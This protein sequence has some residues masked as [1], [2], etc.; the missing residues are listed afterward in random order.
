MMESNEEQGPR[1]AAPRPFG[2]GIS[3]G[4]GDG[5]GA[6]DSGGVGSPAAGRGAP[7]AERGSRRPATFTCALGRVWPRAVAADLEEA[8]A[9][10]VVG[11]TAPLPRPSGSLPALQPGDLEDI[12]GFFP[13]EESRDAAREHF[14]VGSA[15]GEFAGSFAQP[16]GSEEFGPEVEAILLR[17]HNTQ[18][19]GEICARLVQLLGFGRPVIVLSDPKLPVLAEAAVDWVFL[20]APEAPLCL[21]HDEGL[22]VLR[23]AAAWPNLAVELVEPEAGLLSTVVSLR[24]IRSDLVQAQADRVAEETATREREGWFGSGVVAAP[25]APLEVRSAA[26]EPW[27]IAADAD[28]AEAA[29]EIVVRAF[30]PSVLG[31]YAPSALSRVRIPALLFSRVTE[32]LLVRLEEVEEDGRF[33]PPGWILERPEPSDT[34]P[35]AKRLG[36]DEG[37]TLVFERQ[38]ARADGK[39][40]GMVFTNGEP[41]MRSGDGA[42]AFGVLLLMRGD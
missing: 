5:G 23:C 17:P 38:S 11:A 37:A 41:R 20:W 4:A 22:D 36:L 27:Q 33:D 21:L 42:R 15:R 29:E 28:P 6:S 25:L 35:R 1:A 19:F 32:E 2:L 16:S 3:A 24:K 10:L 14:S 26:P 8:L 9:D 18:P 39:P 40:Y 31:G 7:K 30:G 12:L 13:E 34:M